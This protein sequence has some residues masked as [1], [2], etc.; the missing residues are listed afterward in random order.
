[1]RLII[2]FHL[3]HCLADLV[4]VNRVALFH[5]GLNHRPL[6]QYGLFMIGELVLQICKNLP[7]C[8]VILQIFSIVLFEKVSITQVLTKTMSQNE[9]LQF[10][11]QLL[12]FDL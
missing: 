8:G 7:R 4:S 5:I 6:E 3:L 11:N 9:N 10:H 12:L 2:G 1:M